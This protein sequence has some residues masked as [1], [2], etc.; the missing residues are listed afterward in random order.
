MTT[1]RAQQDTL[2]D[3]I[4]EFRPFVSRLEQRLAVERSQPQ[5]DLDLLQ[6]LERER[7]NLRDTLSRA[8]DLAK[9][10]TQSGSSAA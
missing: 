5:P 6:R 1:K 4:G 2:Q 7:D 9:H 10:D 3:R 8:Q